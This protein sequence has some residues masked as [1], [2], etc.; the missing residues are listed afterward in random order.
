MAPLQISAAVCLMTITF[1][2]PPLNE[3]TLGRVFLLRPDFLVPHFGSF[4]ETIRS[5]F[6][7]VQHANPII[8]APSS[9][10]EGII[11]PR[12]WFVSGDKA[13]LLQL[14]QNRF[15]FNWRKTGDAS[16]VR[17]PFIQTKAIELWGKL[18]AFVTRELGRALSPVHNELSYINIIEAEPNQSEFEVAD[19]CMRN[20]KWVGAAGGLGMPRTVSHSAAFRISDDVGDLLVSLSSASRQDNGAPIARLEFTVRGGDPR[21]DGIDFSTWSTRAHDALVAAFRDLTDPKMHS[22]WKLMEGST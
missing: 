8:A 5:D 14:Q 19:W 10:E 16:Y 17:F 20:F 21:T 13:L 22:K 2:A 11:L 1:D 12:V 7:S 9:F 6:P 18:D 15:H 3:V 4:W